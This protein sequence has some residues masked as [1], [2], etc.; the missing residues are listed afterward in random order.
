[1]TRRA[2]RV[3]GVAAR[4]A[5]LA[6]ARVV[7]RVVD[8]G[9]VA[10]W[11]VRGARV[12][13]AS[14]ARA[15]PAIDALVPPEPVDVV[16]NYLR[17]QVLLGL[18]DRRDVRF[19]YR[20]DPERGVIDE[21]SKRIPKRIRTLQ[22]RLGFEVRH[23]HEFAAVLEAT[24]RKVTWITDEIK[25]VYLRLH[26]LGFASSIA[27]YQG[28]ELV[29]GL[30]GIEIGTSFGLLSV[31]HR[32]DHAGSMALIAMV[33]RIGPRWQLVD[34]GLLNPRFE[35]FGA[36]AVPAGEFTDRLLA[37]LHLPQGPAARVADAARSAARPTAGDL[38]NHPNAR[39]RRRPDEV[40][41]GQE[42]GEQSRRRE[43]TRMSGDD[44]AANKIE[45]IAGKA[46]ETVGKVSGNERLEAEGKAEQ[47]K[48]NL[49][50]AGEKIKD[51]FRS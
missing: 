39:Q 20:W 30:W 26:D 19:H 16:A 48:A 29:G 13:A 31:F 27:V 10:V 38:P 11:L 44:K 8:P 35:R 42:D 43:E 22:Q 36:H 33:D 5:L 14:A 25:A 2:R 6:T 37:G 3:A 18:P 7:G 41:G 4:A 12:P 1:V 51:A 49:K 47:G 28:D 24:R 17:G 23:D 45:Q 32:V 46:K 21:Q 9:A 40:L 50:Q 34:V 15:V